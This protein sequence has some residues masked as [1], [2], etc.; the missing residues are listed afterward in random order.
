MAREEVGIGGA[1]VEH[2]RERIELTGASLHGLRFVDAAHCVQVRRVPM[3]SGGVAGIQFDSAKKF[4][5]GARPIPFIPEASEREG[6]MRLAER[7]VDLNGAR[8][9]GGGFRAGF[10]WCE[11]A[12]PAEQAVA[13]GDA[14][15]RTSTA[16]FDG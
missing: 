13:I 6:G 9:R 16:R 1:H 5:F 15:E 8:G 7:S 12:E 2:E 14:R 4:F 3:K 11:R 10:F